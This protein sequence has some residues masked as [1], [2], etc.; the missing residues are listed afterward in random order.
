MVKIKLVFK[1]AFRDLAKQKVRTSMAIIGTLISIG[2]LAI[3]L[4]LSDSIAVSY[5]DYLSADAGGQD[6]LISVRHYNNEPEDRSTFFEYEE[7]IEQIK[8]NDKVKDEID[9]YLPRME[10]KGK[11]YVSEGFSTDELTEIQKSTLISG[12]DFSLEEDLNFGTFIKPDTNE[13]LKLEELDLYQYAI[14][15]GFNDEIRYSKGDEIVIN[16]SIEHG[17]EEIEKEVTLEIDEIFDF[18]LKWPSE[19]RSENLIVVDIKT[20]YDI[21]GEDEFEGRCSKLILTFTNRDIYDIRNVEG[22]KRAVKKIAA[23]IQE[24]LGLNEWNIKLPKLKTLELSEYLTM[25]ITVF[26]VVVSIVAMLIS[27]ILINGILKTSVEERIREFGIFRTLGAYKRYNFFIVL[28]QGFLLSNFGTI[29]GIISAYFMTQFVIIPFA[30]EYLLSGMRFGETFKFSFTWV[31]ILIAYLMGISVGI[32][33][34]IS[35]ALKVARLQLIES[36][37]PY[38]HEDTLYRLRKKA[39]VNIKLVLAGIILCVN[40]GFIWFI[41]PRLLISMNITLLATTFIILLLVFLIGLTLAG[42]G[43]IPLFLRLAIII[44]TPFSRKIIQVIKIFVFRYQRRN[45]STVVTIALSFS[46]V[47]F[48]SSLIQTQTEQ[49]SVLTRLEYGSDLVIKTTGWEERELTYG[50]VYLEDEGFGGGVG[51]DDDV[52][53]STEE[54]EV[55]PNRI[56]TTDSESIV[57]SIDGVE[58]AS[59]VLASPFQLTQIYSEQEKEFEAELADYAGISEE[60]ITLLGIDDEYI[61]TVDTE[62]VVMTRG[63][64]EQSFED[65]FENDDE[66]KCI[67]GE[68]LAVELKLELGDK[69]RI[70]IQRGDESENYEFRIVGM[71]SCMPGFAEEFGASR[72]SADD[73]GVLITQETYLEIVDIPE[74]AWI[75]TIFIK[76]QDNCDEEDIEDIEDEI[77]DLFQNDYDY[78]LFNLER[79]VENQRQM[80]QV[81]NALFMLVLI[82]TVIICLFG[83]L[84]SS[85][86]TI[87]ERTKEIGILR[88]LGLKG[89]EINR[90]FK[91]EASI[92]VLS[93]G[94]IGVLVGWL[95]GWLIASNLNLFNDIPYT[96][97]FPLVNI[98]VIYFLSFAFIWIGMHFML[99]KA[100]RKKIIELYRETQ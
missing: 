82:S 100:R 27:G 92:I 50:D 67:I 30:N 90:M 2:L 28:T 58:R 69:A 97:V 55:D 75:D 59:T 83:L 60:V 4:F 80:F 41:I 38:R 62:N 99:R 14:Y 10:V 23:E 18:E 33:V 77:D 52:S 48:A 66:Y 51:G 7:I 21:F 39:G 61:S 25:F 35:P 11:L 3:V 81:I 40:G 9:D 63:E 95:S 84:A 17:E 70:S 20:L 65:L 12:I 34:S 46:F 96:P 56:M 85:Y 13:E 42:L 24:E 64:M 54:I 31:S 98:L 72:S 74:P 37:H 49:V 5:A 29:F 78:D 79:M 91:I 93:A 71:A 76:V 94:T 15:Y 68:G 32:A 19:Y 73:G 45:L 8:D 1:Y 6:I 86:S 36:I 53:H 22:S 44:F 43:L 16:C 87:I 26:F 89:K 57:E 47:I 88:T